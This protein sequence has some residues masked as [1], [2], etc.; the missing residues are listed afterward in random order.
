MDAPVG[1]VSSGCVPYSGSARPIDP[2]LD[3][4]HAGKVERPLECRASSSAGTVAA[5]L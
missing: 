4:G 5:A 2:A 1:A 3:D